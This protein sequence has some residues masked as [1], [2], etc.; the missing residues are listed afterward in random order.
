M[1]GLGTQLTARVPAPLLTASVDAN[2]VIDE[3]LHVELR[4]F[5][6]YVADRVGSGAPF[7]TFSALVSARLAFAFASLGLA[8][9]LQPSASA[10]SVDF[11]A[12]PS[13]GVR[14]VDRDDVLVRVAFNWLPAGLEWSAKRAVA[15]LWGGWK[16]VGV[17][18]AATPIVL[19]PS[20]GAFFS[21]AL[22]VRLQT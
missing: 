18:L 4:V 13:L 22:C 7:G 3:L 1:F 5:G 20:S 15:E 6:R 10:R 21:A 11:A 9:L 12:G 16:F 17:Q 8:T 19:D 14:L 2:A